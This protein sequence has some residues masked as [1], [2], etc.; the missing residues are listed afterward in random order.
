[1][2]LANLTI[3][4][5]PVQVEAGTTILEA[6]RKIGITDPDPLRLAGDPPH[7]G[8]LPGLHDRG[9]RA[10][11]PH[12][13]LRFSR[14]RGDG[15]QDQHG[16]GAHGPEDGRRTAPGQPSGGVQLLRPERQLRTAEGGRGGGPEA[17]P[18]RHPR[19]S[20]GGDDRPFEPV[21][22]PRRP[23]VHPLPPLH[24]RLRTDP[25]GQRPDPLSPGQQGPGRSLLRPAAGRIELHRLRPVHHGLPRR[26]PLREGRGRRGLEGPA[27]SRRSMSSSRRPR[28]SG[29]P[30]ARSSVYRREP[31]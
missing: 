23:Q 28:R 24:H 30:S 31:S 4:D 22:R 25:D 12:R 11:Q 2:A 20:A 18:L 1:M 21:D 10:A 29:P 13:L 14:Q 6:A 15:R 5:K 26:R 27:G 19:V 8:R 16:T 3:D 9:A 17:R 7:P